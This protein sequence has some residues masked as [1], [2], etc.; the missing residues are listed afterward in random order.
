MHHY[1]YYYI[2]VFVDFL[3]LLKEYVDKFILFFLQRH[4]L[5]TI[6]SISDINNSNHSVYKNPIQILQRSFKIFK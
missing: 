3:Q 5:Q 1:Y 4:H 2:G 6:L